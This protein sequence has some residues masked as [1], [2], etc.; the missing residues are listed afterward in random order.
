MFLP[1]SR[2]E[3]PLFCLENTSVSA[4]LI[5]FPFSRLT[6]SSLL[7]RLS[8]FSAQNRLRN[9]C[10]H[11]FTRR[12]G[13]GHTVAHHC[14][15]FY[16]RIPLCSSVPFPVP[17]LSPPFARYA[18]LSH[19]S[20]TPFNTP[21]TGS[22]HTPFITRATMCIV[23]S[24]VSYRAAILLLFSSVLARRSS[25]RPETRST[26]PPPASTKLFINCIQ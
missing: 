19:H 4:L 21:P 26:G 12:L 15:L 13:I 16:T 1:K 14:R 22:M 6:F 3:S 11:T 2:S 20:T 18:I 8:F 25:V 5:S 17:S 7:F 10:F 9:I 23:R 24:S